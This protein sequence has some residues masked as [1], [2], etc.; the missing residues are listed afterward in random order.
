MSN[1]RDV[2]TLAAKHAIENVLAT[3][4]RGVDRADE[5]LIASAY[6]DD[7][8]VDYGFFTGPARDLAQMLAA[9]QLGRP[10]T[11]HRTSNIW[12]TV[13]G[14][15]ARSESYVIAAIESPGDAPEQRLVGGRY[16]DAHARRDDVWRLTHRRYVMDWN[17][18]QP[19][20][21]SWPAP[22]LALA[23]FVPRGGQGAADPGRALLAV[24]AAGLKH[25]G[26]ETV[27]RKNIDAD[28]DRVLSKQALHELC[29]AYARGVDRGDVG[30]LSS[31]FHDDSS[32]ISGIVNGSGPEFSRRIVEFVR[33]NLE[34][35]FH[36]VANTWFEIDGDG[37]VGESYVIAVATAGGNDVMTGGRYIDAFERRGG[38]WKF[39]SRSFV[40]DWSSTQPTSY[41]TDGMY[42]SL[43]TRG[44]F[45]KDDPVYQHWK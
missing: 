24:A 20:T 18:N 39:K 29:M 35:C 42:A 28:V 30:L 19:S 32:V 1:L 37:A 33:T 34:R 5:G 8:T 7:A 13:D 14:D 3:H 11:M 21:S 25:R 38:I 26:A 44:C 17:I 27:T 16:L 31:L 40:M 10:V 12:T 36:S 43:T 4:S 45:G 41:Q 2:G 9:A 22:S 23:H 6:H 15:T